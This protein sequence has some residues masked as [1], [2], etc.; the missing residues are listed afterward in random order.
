[1]DGGGGG[2]SPLVLSGIR[3]KTGG[4][5]GVKNTENRPERT[6]GVCFVLFVFLPN[7]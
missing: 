1:M 3:L 6:S 7:Y 5:P 4:L 2:G